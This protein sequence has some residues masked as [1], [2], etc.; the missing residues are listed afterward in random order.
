MILPYEFVGDG[1]E[2]KEMHEQAVH[3][4]RCYG[5]YNLKYFI[6]H[7]QCDIFYILV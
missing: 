3:N 4:V 6:Q 1:V 7:R 5:V 2:E